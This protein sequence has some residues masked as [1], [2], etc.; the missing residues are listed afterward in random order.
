MYR[1]SCSGALTPGSSACL[2]AHPALS[3]TKTPISNS[4]S[5]SRAH[6]K[7]WMDRC[8]WL[9]PPLMGR[10]R[11]CMCYDMIYDIVLVRDQS[12]V[13]HRRDP[14]RPLALSS[15]PLSSLQPTNKKWEREKEEKK[16]KRKEKKEKEKKK[17]ERTTLPRERHC[18]F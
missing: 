1:A 15:P 5:R 3:Q 16:R 18:M 11:R 14:R 10:G 12:C 17:V 4:Q 9:P 7:I 13:A 2:S 8:P 6:G